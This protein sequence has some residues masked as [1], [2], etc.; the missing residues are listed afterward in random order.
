MKQTINFHDFCEAFAD[1]DRQ[2]NFSMEGLKIL[3]NYLEGLEEDTG[4]EIELDV[5][6]LCCNYAES[7]IDDLISDY[8]IDI[9]ACD[10]DDA[11]AIKETVL[12]YM[13]CNT[14]VCGETSDG[15]VVYAT[16]LIYF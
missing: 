7:T 8:S 11:E 3:F 5:I 4:M 6:A 9:S 1:Y 12:A 10:P 15:S 2:E 13:E 16:D 14:S